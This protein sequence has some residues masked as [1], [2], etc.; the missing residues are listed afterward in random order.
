MGD[1]NRIPKLRQDAEQLLCRLANKLSNR[2]QDQI[3]INDDLLK[4]LGF[5]SEEALQTAVDCLFRLA[6]EYNW[7][8]RPPLICIENKNLIPGP[9]IEDAWSIYQAWREFEALGE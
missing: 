3:D 7:D 8:G 9:F 2:Y 6:H 5:D 1:P 4:E